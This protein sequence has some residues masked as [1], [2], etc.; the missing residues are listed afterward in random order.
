MFLD[1]EETIVFHYNIPIYGDYSRFS[2]IT[3]AL[4]APQ[5][6]KNKLISCR[7]FCSH[8]GM[9]GN[10]YYSTKNSGYRIT[11]PFICDTFAEFSQFLKDTGKEKEAFWVKNDLHKYVL[12]NIVGVK[13]KR[14]FELSARLFRQCGDKVAETCLNIKKALNGYNFKIIKNRVR[15]FIETEDNIEE[16]DSNYFSASIAILYQ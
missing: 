14:I 6:L 8:E 11:L 10:F 13:Y 7:N 3:S 15:M 1:F 2:D 4:K 9:L 16:P 5:E 12:N